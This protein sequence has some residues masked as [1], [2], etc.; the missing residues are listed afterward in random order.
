MRFGK[1]PLV[2][3]VLVAPEAFDGTDALAGWV[4]RGIEFVSTLPERAR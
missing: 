3:Y 1:Q 2:G 4:Q